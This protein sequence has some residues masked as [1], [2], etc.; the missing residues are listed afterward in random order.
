MAFDSQHAVLLPTADSILNNGLDQVVD[1]VSHMLDLSLAL[2]VD[3][4]YTPC[5][6]CFGEFL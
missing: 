6:E 2:Y 3:H 5:L 1:A 4:L